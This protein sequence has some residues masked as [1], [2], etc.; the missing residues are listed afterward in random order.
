[1]YAYAP[2][3]HTLHTHTHTQVERKEPIGKLIGYLKHEM[4]DRSASVYD[5]Y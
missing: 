5:A 1:M 4:I 2:C 3:T